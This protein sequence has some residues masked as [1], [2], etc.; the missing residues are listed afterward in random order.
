MSIA[1]CPDQ[2]YCEIVPPGT[3]QRRLPF[4][5]T[6]RATDAMTRSGLGLAVGAGVGT[7]VGSAVG[8]ARRERI[9]SVDSGLG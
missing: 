5:E 2:K 3:G 9:G 1:R 7:G 4:P 6:G 8:K